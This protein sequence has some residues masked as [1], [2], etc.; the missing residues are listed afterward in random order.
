MKK[1]DFLKTSA[2]VATTTLLPSSLLASLT[3]N[4]TRLRTAHIGIGG[5]GAADLASIA[6]HKSV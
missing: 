3:K 4:N 2:A 6:S 1:R 5:M